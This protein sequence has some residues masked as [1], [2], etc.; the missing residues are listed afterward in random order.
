MS[1]HVFCALIQLRIIFSDLSSIFQIEIYSIYVSSLSCEHRHNQS[2][3]FLCEFCF[4]SKIVSECEST[5]VNSMLYVCKCKFYQISSRFSLSNVSF[6]LKKKSY[7]I[8]S[9]TST[10]THSTSSTI[11]T[12]IC[13]M[14]T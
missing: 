3:N 5:H 8:H 9:R 13:A 1:V 4:P 2:K 12:A 10:Y 7:N 11:S 14:C 6:Q